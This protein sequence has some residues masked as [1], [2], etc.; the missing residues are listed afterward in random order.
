MFKEYKMKGKRKKLQVENLDYVSP[1][2]MYR[3]KVRINAFKK[4]RTKLEK[5]DK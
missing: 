5:V 2:R 3:L 1:L 4:K